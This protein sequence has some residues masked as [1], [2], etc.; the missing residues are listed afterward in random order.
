M[1][2]ENLVRAAIRVAV[3]PALWRPFLN[4]DPVSRWH[5]RLSRDAEHE[6]WLL[7]WTAEQGVEM[8]D[9]GGSAGAFMV[10]QGQ[11]VE[12][13]VSPRGLRHTLWPAGT[14]R[15]FPAAY[16][17][18][19]WNPGPSTA[20]SIH[21]YSPPLASMTYYERAADGALWAARTERFDE[22][23]AELHP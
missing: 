9:H 8:H 12:D 14:A 13:H 1:T 6:V 20:A 19:V 10:V 3:R 11:L 4:H 5:V 7:G 22:A 2:K 16:V 15:A 17:H 18:H 23:A 21:V